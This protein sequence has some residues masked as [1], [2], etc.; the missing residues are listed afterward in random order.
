MYIQFN[1]QTSQLVVSISIGASCGTAN[2]FLPRRDLLVE[3]TPRALRH[4]PGENEHPALY[5]SV[6][7]EVRVEQ[8]FF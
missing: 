1:S 3:A 5:V 4:R 7:R 8:T 6:H 2:L